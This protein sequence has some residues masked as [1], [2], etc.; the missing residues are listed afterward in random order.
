MTHFGDS[1]SEVEGVGP[2]S[3]RLGIEGKVC[4]KCEV[5][6]VCADFAKNRSRPDGL[7]HW[8]RECQS[9]HRKADSR[10]EEQTKAAQRTN[11]KRSKEYQKRVELSKTFSLPHRDVIHV[12]EP[13]I[14][15]WLRFDN[16]FGHIDCD[17]NYL[18]QYVDY[19]D[20]NNHVYQ[21]LGGDVVEN[22]LTTP[23]KIKHLRTQILS[24]LLQVNYLEDTLKNA[25]V[26]LKG[27]HELRSDNIDL[28]LE[29]F[30]ESRMDANNVQIFSDNN[31]L[32]TLVVNDIHY[33]FMLTH[34]TGASQKPEYLVDRLLRDQLVPDEVDFLVIGHTHHNSKEIPRDRAVRN[35]GTIATKRLIGIRAGGFLYNPD[36]LKYGRE[37]ISG[38]VIL[39]L[40][41]ETWNYR[42]F[43][44]L[45]ELKESVL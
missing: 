28:S 45:T 43:E 20:D 5:Y 26:Y 19:L 27:N 37:S 16:H 39:R 12:Q 10:T 25:L 33:T 44:N 42:V 7:Q 8:C 30:L 32:Y 41:A 36:Y 23:D 35:G 21:I 2:P 17:T 14:D 4:A 24:P 3:L 18:Y 38:N 9:T 22:V 40:S 29:S 34:G 6:R 13:F 15:I 11:I 31:L 1:Q